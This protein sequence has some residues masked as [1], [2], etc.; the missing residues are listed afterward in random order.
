M[1]I[2]PPFQEWLLRLAREGDQYVLAAYEI[3]EVGGPF[4]LNFLVLC[5]RLAHHLYRV[6][7][8]RSYF[9]SC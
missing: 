9:Y 2:R 3:Y 5:D 7:V 6:F 1:G 8:P 4:S